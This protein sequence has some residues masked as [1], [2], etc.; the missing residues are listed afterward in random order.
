MLTYL[1]SILTC[2]NTQDL[3]MKTGKGIA[4]L[5]V[6]KNNFMNNQCNVFDKINCHCKVIGKVIKTCNDENSISLL[7]KTGQEEFYEKF[8]EK[9]QCLIECLKNHDIMV[10]VC[11]DLRVSECAIQIMPINI[12]V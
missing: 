3:V 6:S 11:P 7:R 12:Y 10:P 5:T 8:F 9:T 4:I 2:N 1:E